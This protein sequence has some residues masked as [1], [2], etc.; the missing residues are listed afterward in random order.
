MMLFENFFSKKTQMPTPA[1]ALP[2]RSDA[3]ATSEFHFVNQMSLKGPWPD[4]LETAYFGMGCFWGVERLYWQIE[5][6]F[7]TATG[8]AGGITPNP[9][10]EETVTGQ[11]GH[12]EIVQ[13]VFDSRK[14][15]FEQLLKTFWEEHDPTQ[16]MRQGNDVG[17]TYRS[18]IYTTTRAQLEAAK[19]SLKQYQKNL[20]KAGV[21]S[22]ITTEI[23]PLD[24]FYYA[25]GYHQQYL[26]K[27]PGGYCN[28]RG[29]GVTCVKS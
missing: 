13:V 8:Y 4:N 12:T 26:A 24:T 16:G 14:V 5:G 2:G 17:T 6:V 19:L 20:S 15:T 25:E 3:I 29:T 11:T 28:L 22:E 7:V 1:D 18:A 21:S 10:Y 23:K 9:T 27:N